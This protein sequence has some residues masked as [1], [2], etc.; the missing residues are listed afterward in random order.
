MPRVPYICPATSRPLRATDHGLLRDDGKIYP[1]LVSDADLAH[2][3]PDFLNLAEAGAGSRTSLGM[4]N[5]QAA[6]A[7][8]RNFLDWLFATFRADEAAFRRDMAARL[9]LSPGATVLVTG[10]G[11]GDDIPAILDLVGPTGEVHA[12]DLSPAMTH[13]AAAQ[14]R[15]EHPEQAAQ[16]WFST[17]D[18]LRLPFADGAFD[19]AFHFGGINLFDNVGQGIAEMNRV[20][21]PGG[22]VVVSDEGIGPWLRDTDFGR[23]VI[24]NNRLWAHAAPIER[25]PPTAT[26]VGLTWLLGNCFWLI[27]FTVAETLPA[28]DPDVLHK[29]WRGGSMRTRH[30]GQLEAVTPETRAKV[31]EAAA[32]AGI[33]VHDWLERVLGEQLPPSRDSG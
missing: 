31:I 7:V 29:G 5:T 10:C 19:A 11:L 8:Y 30:L 33:S 28:I 14:W 32:A 9:R 24:T 3:V 4:Y 21:R 20:V 22:R 12:Q 18:A 6:T 17:G 1:Y 23:M 26:E 27:D 13:E 15:R 16:V 2:A 25:L